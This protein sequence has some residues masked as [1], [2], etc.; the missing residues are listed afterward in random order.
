MIP[1]PKELRRSSLSENFIRI[2]AHKI[3]GCKVYPNTTQL[4]IEI[5]IPEVYV[6]VVIKA[7]E[8]AGWVNCYYNSTFHTL[9]VGFPEE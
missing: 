7:C 6:S 3:K 9:I 4:K 8:D 1:S 2:V 5:R